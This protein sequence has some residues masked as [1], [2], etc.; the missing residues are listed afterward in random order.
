MFDQVVLELLKSVLKS[1]MKDSRQEIQLTHLFK[2]LLLVIIMLVR[3]IQMKFI[4]KSLVVEQ[5]V[6]W[7]F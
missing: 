5:K 4:L 1:V 2:D 7:L 6:K 3:N